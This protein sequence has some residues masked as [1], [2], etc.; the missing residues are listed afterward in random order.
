M[1]KKPALTLGKINHDL[2]EPVSRNIFRNV[3]EQVSNTKRPPRQQRLLGFNTDRTP[4]QTGLPVPSTFMVDVL[5]QV[6]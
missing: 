6:W 5:S 3:L 4:F 1:Q 2:T